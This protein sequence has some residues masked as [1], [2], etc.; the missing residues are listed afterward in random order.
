[1]SLLVHVSSSFFRFMCTRHVFCGLAW[2]ASFITSV[3]PGDESHL[4]SVCAVPQT[5]VFACC[6][7]NAN[8]AFN[9]AVDLPSPPPPSPPPSPPPPPPLPPQPPRL[10]GPC[11]APNSTS[12]CG[13]CPGYSNIQPN[14]RILG[15]TVCPL[16]QVH[17]DAIH[18]S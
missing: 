10:D 9:F 5:F 13:E 8:G 15:L 7:Y 17:R 1:M 18:R 2:P 12:P 14:P 4:T 3:S 11:S 6:G 16:I